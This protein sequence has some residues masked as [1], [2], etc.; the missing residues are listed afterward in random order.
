MLFSRPFSVSQ[1]NSIP[2]CTN[3]RSESSRIRSECISDIHT[4]F[5]RCWGHFDNC[6]QIIIPSA[7]DDGPILCCCYTSSST[8][9]CLRELHTQ[10]LNNDCTVGYGDISAKAEPILPFPTI[11]TTDSPYRKLNSA[12]LGKEVPC[13][14]EIH[15]ADHRLGRS[16]T[17]RLDSWPARQPKSS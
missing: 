6:G 8:H 14:R 4:L 3:T 5:P 10:S 11:V 13:F 9:H 15:L 12:L 1:G 2:F 17:E 16:T 7:D